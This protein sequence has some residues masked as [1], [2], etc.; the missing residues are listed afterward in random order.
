MLNMLLIFFEQGLKIIWEGTSLELPLCAMTLVWFHLDLICR[1]VLLVVMGAHLS[2]SDL[3]AYVIW[4][5]N[6]QEVQANN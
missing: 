6:I 4:W 1:N 3:R 5:H 2:G